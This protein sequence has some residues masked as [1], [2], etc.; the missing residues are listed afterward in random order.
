M[1]PAYTASVQ[2]LE[3]CRTALGPDHRNT[4]VATSTELL[5]LK[6]VFRKEELGSDC[7]T[8]VTNLMKHIRNDTSSVFSEEDR[9]SLIET[10]SSRLSSSSSSPLASD[11]K[12]GQK[13]QT[14]DYTFNYY[15]DE[16]WTVL[17]D[18]NKSMEYKMKSIS[19]EWLSWGLIFPSAPTFRSGVSTLMVTSNLEASPDQAKSFFNQFC[20]VFRNLRDVH[21]RSNPAATMKEFPETP[22]EF[23]AQYPNMVRNPAPCR[24]DVL[25]VQE[26]STP[27]SVPCRKNNSMLQSQTSVSQQKSKSSAAVADS[28]VAAMAALLDIVMNRAPAAPL[29]APPAAPLAHQSEHCRPTRRLSLK[30]TLASWHC[31]YMSIACVLP[32]F[33]F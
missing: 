17:L 32:C 21:R 1:L 28:S 23:E 13:C 6:N 5:H 12:G 16:V 22:A 11:L 33:V 9:T 27:S 10:A 15:S 3:E 29:V 24:V 4:A 7:R 26:L 19:R 30:S 18:L 31:L 8:S 20:T 25:S 2:Y 14:H